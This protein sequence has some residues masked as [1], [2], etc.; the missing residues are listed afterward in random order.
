VH[1]L[2]RAAFW[3]QMSDEEQMNALDTASKYVLEA[4]KLESPPSIQESRFY[5]HI[6]SL[7]Q[8]NIVNRPP[9]LKELEECVESAKT[10]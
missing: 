1:R 10:E 9:S 5:R 3:E 7:L 2:V 8:A 4:I 6:S